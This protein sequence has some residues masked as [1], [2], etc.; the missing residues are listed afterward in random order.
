MEI[1]NITDHALDVI[2]PTGEATVEAGG[3]IDVPDEIATGEPARDDYPGTTGLVGTG[4]FEVV[5]S[6]KGAPASD[7]P[8]AGEEE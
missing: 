2:L 8:P 3:V 7:N 5:K 6:K 4:R 1:R